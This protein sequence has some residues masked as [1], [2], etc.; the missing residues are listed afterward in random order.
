MVVFVWGNWP[1]LFK[2]SS[3]C[4]ELFVE[5]LSILLMSVGS[6]VLPCFIPDIGDLYLILTSFARSLSI[7]FIFSENKLFVS[8]IVSVLLL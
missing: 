2:L 8:C 6:I 3:L 4:F 7:L 5:F 1:I